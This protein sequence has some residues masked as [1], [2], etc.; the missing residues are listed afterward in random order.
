LHNFKLDA[1]K[2]IPLPA[3]VAEVTKKLI[4]KHNPKWKLGG[5][6]GIHQRC[7]GDMA[8]ADFVPWKR[9]L[10]TSTCSTRA[11]RGVG[12]SLPPE[13]VAA[14]DSTCRRCSPR[15]FLKSRSPCSIAFSPRSEGRR[16]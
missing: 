2:M 11:R 6:M 7:L 9:S 3:N 12:A 16:N 14:F 8:L 13:G 4:E 10:S 1:L 15:N 5:S